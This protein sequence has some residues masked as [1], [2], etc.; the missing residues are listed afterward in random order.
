MNNFDD[1]LKQ[2][3]ENEKTEI[4][5]QIKNKIEKSLAELP[6]SRSKTVKFKPISKAISFA[7]CI[8]FV[9]FVLIPNCSSVYAK[10]LEKI[11]LIGNFVRVVTIRNYFYKDNYHEMNIDVPKIEDDNSEAANYINNDVSELTQILVD[12]FNA[13]LEEIGDEGHSSVYLQ[14]DVVTNSEKWFTL[15]ITVFEAAGSSNTYYKYYHIDKQS[16]KIVN[17]ND[18]VANDKFYEVV[19][20]EIKRQMKNEMETN[21][22]KTYWLEK[23]DFGWEFTTLEKNHNFYWNENYDLIIS[24]DK[25]EVAPGSMG[26]P[27]F[28]IENSIFKEYLK[29]EIQDLCK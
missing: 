27:Q 10:T 23:S 14:Y 12:R 2:K 17:L 22:N 25:Y 7:A 28:V 4:P 13:D 24:F 6:E 20:N 18:L 19:E 8:V 5:D 1:F 26:T 29:S 9:F 16:G 3:I 11:P 21:P 15:K